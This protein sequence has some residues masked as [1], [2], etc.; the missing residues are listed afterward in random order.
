MHDQ[1]VDCVGTTYDEIKVLAHGAAFAVCAQALQCWLGFVQES[2]WDGAGARGC[3]YLNRGLQLEV[4]CAGGARC[5]VYGGWDVLGL[6]P[7]VPV[8]KV[9]PQL[10]PAVEGGLGFRED[11]SRYRVDR[12]IETAW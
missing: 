12:C 9:C 3:P 6:D 11:V 1:G 2:G 10:G 4:I 7:D 5:Q 8:V